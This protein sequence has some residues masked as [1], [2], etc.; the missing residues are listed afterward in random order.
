[1]EDRVC[2]SLSVFADIVF[3]RSWSA[4]WLDPANWKTEGRVTTEPVPHLERIPCS[5]DHVVFPEGSSF[6]VRLPEMAVTVGAISLLGQVLPHHSSS[7]V[8]IAWWYWQA[9]VR[10]SV[11]ILHVLPLNFVWIQLINK[12]HSWLI[13]KLLEIELNSFYSCKNPY[14]HRIAAWLWNIANFNKYS[15]FWDPS[16]I[17][18]LRLLPWAHHSYWPSPIYS[19]TVLCWTLVIFSVS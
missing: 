15:P 8:T 9:W 2:S 1:M 18:P 7:C 6:R 4:A 3:T 12:E 5:H 13:I 14:V 17:K 11:N 16:F 19:S 10:F